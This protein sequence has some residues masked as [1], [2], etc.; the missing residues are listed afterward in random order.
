MAILANADGKIMYQLGDTRDDLRPYDTRLGADGNVWK[1]TAAA[2][3]SLTIC[4][5][6]VDGK[7]Y[8]TETENI[9]VPGTATGEETPSQPD[10]PSQLDQPS[11]SGSVAALRG[12]KNRKSVYNRGDE[13][14]FGKES[15]TM[16]KMLLAFML[17]LLTPFEIAYGLVM[18]VLMPLGVPDVLGI[19]NTE[20]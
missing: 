7:T 3:G 12:C 19:M 14:I 9:S 1:V 6:T 4:G 16:W 11:E 13:S 17:P 20:D 2:E 5:T 15:C 10:T 8:K 18:K